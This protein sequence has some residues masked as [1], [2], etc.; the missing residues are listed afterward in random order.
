MSSP[1][2][3]VGTVVALLAVATPADAQLGAI[4]KGL[5][6]AGQTSADTLEKSKDVMVDLAKVEITDQ[7]EQDLGAKVSAQLRQKYGVAQSAAVHKY[8]AL[9]GTVLAKASTRPAL[10]WHFIV[11]DTDGV[12]AF[13]APGGYVHITR[14]ALA[15]IQNESELA[16]VLGHEIAH[17][18]LKH[19]IEAIKKSKRVEKIAGQTRLA[20]IT[21]LADRIYEMTFENVYDRGDEKEA[22]RAGVALANAAGYAPSGLNAFLTRLSERNRGL[23]ERSGLFAS[24]PEASDRIEEVKKEIDRQKLTAK[25]VVAG[26]YRQT[27]T[28]KPVPVDQVEFVAGPDGSAGALPADGKKAEKKAPEKSSGSKFGLSK[29]TTLGKEKQST[30]T[31]ASAGSRGVNPDRDAKGGSNPTPVAVTVSTAELTAFRKGIV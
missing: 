7:E 23:K 21:A 6:K 5:K 27:I 1:L 16:G 10:K 14:G 19:T 3:A 20:V 13:A 18:T 28:Y 31:V 2:P 26:R 22:D 17:V 29:L 11:L 12:N 25:A 30:Q 15:L 24:H 9:V 8:V 4:K